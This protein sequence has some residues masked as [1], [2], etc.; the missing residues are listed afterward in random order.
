M[1]KFSSFLYPQRCP[2]CDGI[3][4][5]IRPQ[6]CPDCRRKIPVCREPRCVICGKKV[7]SDREMYCSDCMEL[8]HEFLQGRSAWMYDGVV[9]RSLY[10]FKFANRRMYA[11]F[12]A[13]EMMRQMGHWLMTRDADAL[14]PVPVSRKKLHARGYNQAALLARELGVYTRIEVRGDLL[15]RREGFVQQKALSRTL[16]RQNLRHAFYVPDGA[17]VPRT[18]ILVD[19]IYTTGSTIDAASHV[20]RRAGV[21]NI[22]AAYLC[23]GES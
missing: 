10:R 20:L 21:K 12:Y 23:V 9:R 3:V 1:M 19:D 2:I 11:P 16:R 5:M 7:L 15:L 18:V 13:Q 8:S 4:D 22:Y 17:Q 6:I 14:I